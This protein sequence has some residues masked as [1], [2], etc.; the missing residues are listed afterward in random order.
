MTEQTEK[1]ILRML[2]NQE[3]FNKKFIEKLES[4]EKK[5]DLFEKELGYVKNDLSQVK[6][7]LSHVKE[8]LNNV[9]SDLDY[10]KEDLNNVKSDLDYVKD[11]LNNVKSD[12]N[13]VKSD[14]KYVKKDLRKFSQHFAVFEV[15]FSRKVDVLFENY[16]T[17]FDEH[18]I[19]KKDIDLLKNSSFK[20]D[21]QIEH[22]S[23]KVSNS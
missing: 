2:K 22:L 20:H 11:D 12:L 21:V 3:N 9:K 18:K 1:E 15:E 6:E 8:D 4:F 13:N 19:F 14:L 16:G 5:Q 17:D 7:D 10:V 23:K